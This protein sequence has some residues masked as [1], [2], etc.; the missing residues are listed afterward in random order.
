MAAVLVVTSGCGG[1]RAEGGRTG[2]GGVLVVLNAGS[3]ARPLH[4]ALDSFARAEGIAVEQAST[5]SLEAARR[6]TELGQNPDLLA[7]ADEE[8]FSRLLMPAHVGWYVRFARNRMVLAYTDRSRDA[9]ELGTA[10]WMDVVT[11]RGTEVGRADPDLDP[12]GYRTLLMFELAGLH[13]ADR[14]LPARLLAAAPQRT[15]RPK[16]A[17]LVGLL[18]AGEL[19]YIYIYESVARAA[20]LRY[21]HFPPQIDLGSPAESAR[22]A[23]VS[24][25]VAGQT[26]RDTLRFRGEPIVFA[27][28]VPKGAPNPELALRAAAFL[29][30]PAG[31][32]IMGAAE[33]DVLDTLTS[34]G[35]DLPPVIDSMVRGANEL[36]AT[37]SLA[38]RGRLSRRGMAP[39]NRR[40][41]TVKASQSEIRSS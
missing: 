16:S 34:A 12:A 41:P 38:P 26:P 23:R 35:A 21:L 13:Y 9:G 30:S 3:L 11:R 24:V 25:A 39:V 18:Q 36:P 1:D 17:E 5:G 31:R 10:T 7:L 40:G 20:G 33:L 6:L 8:V 4:E 29:L 19:D 15:V 28:A 22:Y 37:D 2:D 14:A 27:L 32:R